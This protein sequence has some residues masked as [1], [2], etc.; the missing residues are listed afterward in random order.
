MSRGEKQQLY[1]ISSPQRIFEDSDF[2]GDKGENDKEKCDH[3]KNA[4]RQFG[5]FAGLRFLFEEPCFIDICRG[6]RDKKDGNI[7]PIRRLS[8]HSVI[9]IK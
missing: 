8:N 1:A 4:K 5:R 3:A 2:G 6:G 9:G 7:D